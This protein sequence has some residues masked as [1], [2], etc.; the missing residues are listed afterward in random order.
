MLQVYLIRHGETKWNVSRRIQGHS[1]SP[2]TKI[3]IKQS[4][5]LAERIKKIG[6]THILS[7]DLERTKK[8]AEIISRFCQC[9][10]TLEPKLREI[11]MGILEGRKIKTLNK[12]EK[13]WC[14]K[15]INGFPGAR[16]PNGESIEETTHRMFSILEKCRFFPSGSMP[17]L[18]SHGISIGILLNYIL[19]VPIHNRRKLYVRNCSLSKIDYQETNDFGNGWIVETTGD[20]AHLFEKIKREEKKIIF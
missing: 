11:N 7:S 4:I 10:I 1:N 13:K 9:K 19:G 16:I 6:I 2:L 8:T 14:K 5:L 18:I 12:K 20:T 3:G 15:L 17:L